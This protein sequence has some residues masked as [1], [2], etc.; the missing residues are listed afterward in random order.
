LFAEP[1]WQTAGPP[2]N[3]IGQ[4]SWLRFLKYHENAMGSIGRMRIWGIALA[5]PLFERSGCA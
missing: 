3:Y 2:L 1:G 5:G 4:T